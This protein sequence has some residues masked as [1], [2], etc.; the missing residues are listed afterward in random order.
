[1][2]AGL[3]AT[4]RRFIG[5]LLLLFL[6]AVALAHESAHAAHA[7][8]A[9]RHDM[10]KMWA[11][12][13]SRAAGTGVSV[14]ADENGGLWLARMQ[15]GHI[16]VSRSDD[17][18]KSFPAGVKVN[19]LPEGILA[20]G[21]NR[22][23]IAVRGGVVAVLWAQALPRVFAGHI[24]FAR[25]LDGGKTFS[26]PQT[27]NDN[28]EEIGH[29]FP[30]LAMRDG[31]RIAIAWL[32]ARE[33]SAS[34]MADRKYVGSAVYYAVS[35]DA[36]ATFAGNQKLADHSCECCRV[37]LAFDH[38]GVAVAFWR[39]V[40]GANIRDFAM[41]RLEAQGRL[42]RASEDNWEISACPHHGGDIAIDAEGGRHMVWFTGN[43]QRAG[44]FYRRADGTR[45]GAPRA[46]G[47][48]DAQAGN[49]AVFVRGKS[50]HIA[51]REFD[52]QRYR[53]MGMNSDDRGESWSPVRALGS[54]AGA[55][56]LPL[57][58]AGAGRPWLAWSSAAEG[59]R[60]FDM[61]TLQ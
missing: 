32:D 56:D 14:A 34:S 27:I 57:F 33:K 53:L 11:D 28:R 16:L 24:R 48:P 42:Q 37:A 25:S 39:H 61:D 18:G 38:D 47:D 23:K 60:I 50:V 44:L 55:A 9:P 40:F 10:A 41:A 13:L 54:S 1:M 12:N 45:M 26:E 21:Q 51:W 46:F 20:D 4:G 58:V 3:G 2:M 59:V 7:P 22:P 35:D 5:G 6:S 36:G 19:P 49:P 8:A 17:G 31:G 29:G 15:G 30:A 52:G 43:P